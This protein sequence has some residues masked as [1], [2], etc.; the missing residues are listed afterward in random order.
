M[1]H[2]QGLL[3]HRMKTK[4]K[5]LLTLVTDCVRKFAI[6]SWMKGHATPQK[7]SKQKKKARKFALVCKSAVIYLWVKRCKNKA[8][9]IVQFWLRTLS[10]QWTAGFLRGACRALPLALLWI[11]PAVIHP[12]PLL[13]AP[14]RRSC[15]RC[16]GGWA[17]RGGRQRD[18][19]SPSDA[20][21]MSSFNFHTVFLILFNK[22]K[23]AESVVASHT[24]HVQLFCTG[25]SGHYGLQD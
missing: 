5:Q 13:A 23:L 20:D 19:C 11:S 17:C 15:Q 2:L 8:V 16:F 7:C 6:G 25:F 1:L 22:N 14:G 3:Y 18:R 10:Q 21:G 4:S 9:H 24:L 12:L